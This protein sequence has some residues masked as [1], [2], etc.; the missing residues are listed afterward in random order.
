MG[1]KWENDALLVFKL[2]IATELH[3]L[4][5]GNFGLKQFVAY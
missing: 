2:K 3:M 5:T 1:L 4:V